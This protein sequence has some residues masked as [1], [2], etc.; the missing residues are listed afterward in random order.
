M[1]WSHGQSGFP[2][3]NIENIYLEPKLYG[4]VKTILPSMQ[5]LISF[6]SSWCLFLWLAISWTKFVK[7]RC[8][9]HS[10][11]RKPWLKAAATTDQPIPSSPPWMMNR[12]LVYWM[13]LVWGGGKQQQF[14]RLDVGRIASDAN[15]AQLAISQAKV[16]LSEK[17]FGNEKKILYQ[18]WNTSPPNAIEFSLAEIVNHVP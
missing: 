2:H 10:N 13:Y 14:G 3:T 9:F 11:A 16:A 5:F 18:P 12:C 1:H 8:Q 6:D 17:R 4:R 15:N 7:E